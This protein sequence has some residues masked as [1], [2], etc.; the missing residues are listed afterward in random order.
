[1]PVKYRKAENPNALKEFPYLVREVVHGHS[2]PYDPCFHVMHWHPELQFLYVENG[3]IQV[4]TLQTAVFVGKGE[5]IFINKDMIHCIQ[6]VGDSASTHYFNLLFPAD[7][8][9]FYPGCPANDELA[10]VL[11]GSSLPLYHLT[12][13]TDWEKKA[14]SLLQELVAFQHQAP[15]CYAYAVLLRLFQLVLLLREN[16]PFQLSAKGSDTNTVRTKQVLQYMAAHYKE[17]LS[18]DDLAKSAHCSKS[19]CLRAFHV[20]MGTTPFKYLIDYRLEQAALQLRQTSEPVG[21]IA[22]AAGFNQVSLFGKYFK[23]KT[24]M[25]PREYRSLKTTNP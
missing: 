18:L 10:F 20:C 22:L 1:M 24:G 12:A 11:D 23:A 14:L 19:A 5:S 4:Q 16:C 17:E 9:R 2:T 15:G 3:T 21:N 13:G 8:L 6:A 25:T 7:V